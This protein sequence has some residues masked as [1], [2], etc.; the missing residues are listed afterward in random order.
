MDKFKLLR[1]HFKSERESL[2]R[3]LDSAKQTRDDAPSAMESHHDTTR[4]QT[5]KLVVALEQDLAKLDKN[6]DLIPKDDPEPADKVS[7]W[8]YV[9]LDFD[10]NQMKII[11]VPEGMGG[12]DIDGIKLISDQTPLGGVLLNKPKEGKLNFNGKSVSILKV[13]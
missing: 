11:I 9:E 8:S 2:M 4:N 12:S 13:A 10:G 5:E 7:L 1:E 3:A 6:I